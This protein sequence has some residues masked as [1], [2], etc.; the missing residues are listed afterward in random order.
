MYN[1]LKDFAKKLIDI[2]EGKYDVLGY[3]VTSSIEGLLNILKK[4]S[5]R[6][7]KF[8]LEEL[9]ILL[10]RSVFERIK[11]SPLKSC[12]YCCSWDVEP[13]GDRY[14]CSECDETFLE[15]HE[16]VKLRDLLKLL[17]HYYKGLGKSNHYVFDYFV[18]ILRI[19]A[20]PATV[21]RWLEEDLPLVVYD[22]VE[23][24]VFTLAEYLFWWIYDKPL[25]REKLRREMEAKR[26][27]ELKKRLEERKRKKSWKRYSTLT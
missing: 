9:A 8:L 11:N 5:P 22:D 4:A 6:D 23:A 18:N 14:R 10:K 27:L 19:K 21:L 26:R 3:T 15:S 20:S 12:P 13:L 24:E 16:E 1:S 25:V 17:A 2:V 7:H